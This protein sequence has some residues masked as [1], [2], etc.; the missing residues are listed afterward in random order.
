MSHKGNNRKNCYYLS[1]W[2]II[3]IGVVSSH[4]ISLYYSVTMDMYV[5]V[6]SSPQLASGDLSGARLFR[7]QV[8]W[9]PYQSLL[10]VDCCWGWLQPCA[11]RK[12]GW[13]GNRIHSRL[14]QIHL[15]RRLHWT[16]RRTA[17][18]RPRTTCSYRG[19]IQRYM[20]TNPCAQVLKGSAN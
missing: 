7:C 11:R 18:S 13:V 5:Q 15:K 4:S 16:L 9:F 3:F 14:G 17:T 6:N 8:R 20:L 10:L 12:G 1:A 19:K 2:I